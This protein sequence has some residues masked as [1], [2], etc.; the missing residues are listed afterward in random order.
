[1]PQRREIERL[2]P[3]RNGFATGKGITVR[4]RQSPSNRGG[5]VANR[6]WRCNNLLARLNVFINQR[7]F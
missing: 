1:M 3:S 5:C 2:F 6:C 4:L 7:L